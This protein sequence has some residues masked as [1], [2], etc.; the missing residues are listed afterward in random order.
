MQ[1]GKRMSD[2][3][4]LRDHLLAEARATGR[5]NPLLEVTVPLGGEG[6]FHDY[7]S[8]AKTKPDGMSGAGPITHCEIEA[9]TR[10]MGIMLTPWEVETITM[11][12]HAARVKAQEKVH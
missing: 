9:Y 6:V 1:L 3:S 10:L 2:G 8:L 11:M 12:D 4:P 5:R 7:A